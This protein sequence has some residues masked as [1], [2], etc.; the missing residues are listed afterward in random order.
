ML[1]NNQNYKVFRNRKTKFKEIVYFKRFNLTK[2]DFIEL[3]DGYILEESFEQN[4]L[5]I[6]IRIHINSKNIFDLFSAPNYKR[7]HI[8]GTIDNFSISISTEHLVTKGQT[9]SINSGGKHDTVSYLFNLTGLRKNFYTLGGLRHKS[10]KRKNA[11][12]TEQGPI[13]AISHDSKMAAP[14]SSVP[15]HISWAISHPFQGGRV[16]P[17]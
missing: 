16:S 15:N 9:V 7:F 3:C 17:R 5:K 4:G 6:N 14:K 13:A 2:N 1:H 12:K 10:R 11:V 8:N